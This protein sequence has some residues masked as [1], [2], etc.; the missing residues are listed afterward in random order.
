MVSVKSFILT[1]LVLGALSLSHAFADG[2][3]RLIERKDEMQELAEKIRSAPVVTEYELVQVTYNRKDDPGFVVVATE[4]DIVEVEDRRRGPSSM[5]EGEPEYPRRRATLLTDENGTELL[6]SKAVINVRLVQFGE[7]HLVEQ[8]FPQYREG[9]PEPPARFAGIPAPDLDEDGVWHRLIERNGARLFQHYSSHGL[10]REMTGDDVPRLGAYA[11]FT[12]RAYAA[13]VSRAYGSDLEEATV[14]TTDDGVFLETRDGAF[15]YRAEITED[16]DLLIRNWGDPEAGD[17]VTYR[18]E[19]DLIGMKFPTERELITRELDGTLKTRQL[20]R[21]IR[22]RIAD[23]GEV[24]E[25]LDSWF[26]D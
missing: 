23:P 4:G 3:E 5:F 22:L 13:S 1:I 9:R 26:N 15:P 8:G 21:N 12:P 6:E 2:L 20:V 7:D 16:G 18:G 17:S 14:R 25:E 19:Q 10:F 11:P 24:E